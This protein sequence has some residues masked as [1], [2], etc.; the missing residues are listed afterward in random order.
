MIKRKGEGGTSSSSSVDPDSVGWDEVPD[1]VTRRTVMVNIYGDTGTGRTRFALTAPGPIALAHTAEKVDGL[2]QWAKRPIPQGGLGKVIRTHN[3]GGAFTAPTNQ[4]I[5]DLVAPVWNRMV[6]NWNAA[7]DTWARTAIM[8]TDSEAWEECRL[9]HFGELNP[10]GR[11]DNLYGPVNAR[12]RALWKRHKRAEKCNVIAISQS[13]DEYRDK[14]TPKG[15]VSERTGRTIRTG[16]KEIGFMS[17]VIV[18]CTKNDGVFAVTI[19]K[20]WYNGAAEGITL[21][22]EDATFARVMSLITETEEEEWS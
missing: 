1:D 4:G 7:I 11:I 20:G 12:W 2:I 10:K 3:F 9:A 16:Q 6:A 21:E 14:K 18:R 19:E 17:D 22:N 8:D 13:K 5:A 15:I